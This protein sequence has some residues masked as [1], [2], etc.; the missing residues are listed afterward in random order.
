MGNLSTKTSETLK[1]ARRASSETQKG[2][3][4][5]LRVNAA[6]I[7]RYEN[8]EILP[9]VTKAV[10]LADILEI[11]KG[12]FMRNHAADAL[13]GLVRDYRKFADI[14]GVIG[15]AIATLRE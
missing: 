15:A 12:E 9:P 14:S 4:K 10:K 3:A 11:P 2:I 7:S 6:T 5:T 8:G 1:S 13:T